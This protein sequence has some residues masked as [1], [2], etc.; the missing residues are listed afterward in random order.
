MLRQ[1]LTGLRFL[2]A[3]LVLVSCSSD[4][5]S[6]YHDTAALE[7]PPVLITPKTLTAAN[8][9]DESSIP[10]KQEPGL[11]EQV[12]LTEASPPRL[13]IKQPFAKAWDTLNQALKISGIKI[14][15][16]ERDKGHI[17]VAYDASGFFAKAASLLEQSQ[18]ERTY[19]LLVESAEAEAKISASLAG[20]AEQAVTANSA[21]DDASPPEDASDELL[22][23][24]YK[25]IRDDLV[26]E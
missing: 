21:S 19:L 1:I 8:L 5:D 11:G 4:G 3:I 12:A 23:T 2:S 22:E 15:D 13:I 24:L 18:K 9:T 16:H 7:R 20:S 10:E 17:Y 25:T 14:T 26:A 6:R